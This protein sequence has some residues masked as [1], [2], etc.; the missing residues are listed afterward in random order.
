MYDYHLHSD[1]SFDSTEK[2]I[3]MIQAALDMGLKEI[4]FTDHG[5]T[6][7]YGK[8][9]LTFSRKEYLEA[10][11]KFMGKE[12]PVKV[13]F[14]AEIGA[15]PWDISSYDNIAATY[16][17]DFIILSAH[18]VGKEDPY[19]AEYF[20]P[21][22]RRQAFEEYMQE[23]I[24]DIDTH[25]NY[26]VLGH[27]TFVSKCCPLDDPIVH[28]S[29]FCDYYDEIFKKLITRGKGIEINTSGYKNTGEPLPPYE[30]VKRYIDMGGE[31]ITLG[32]DAHD[33]YR[34][35]EHVFEAVERLKQ[36]GAKYI[37][38]FDKL[39]PIFNRI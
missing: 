38:T 23:V 39:K 37:C 18:F 27:L 6:D 11:E 4:C 15:A 7:P 8:K 9:I 12:L 1:V 30:A 25:D 16:D 24:R 28:Y 3:D 2:A 19:F 20:K 33:R 14:G 5:D 34:V 10:Y 26:S 22:T 29:E 35:G 36:M 13:K 32:S 21:R 17:F 31:I